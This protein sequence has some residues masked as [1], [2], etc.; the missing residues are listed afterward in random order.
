MWDIWPNIGL[1]SKDLLIMKKGGKAV[2]WAIVLCIW[3]RLNRYDRQIQC[4]NPD[5]ILDQEVQTKTIND[6]LGAL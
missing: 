1:H 2:V 3:V 6:T 5:W 4:V